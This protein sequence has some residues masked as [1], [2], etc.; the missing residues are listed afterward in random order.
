MQETTSKCADRISEALKSRE[1]DIK[2]LMS[3]D[4]DEDYQQLCEIPLGIETVKET[5]ITLS[6]GGPADYLH[7]IHANGEVKRVT[8]RFSDWFDTAIDELDETSPLWDYAESIVESLE[9]D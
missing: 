5:T 8:Y 3:S 6:W 7:I 4:N 9:L 2:F 1:E